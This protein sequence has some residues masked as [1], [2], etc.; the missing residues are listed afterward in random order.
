MRSPPL[1]SITTLS[2]ATQAQITPDNTLGNENSTVTPDA[3][4][5]GD[6]ADLIEGGA[7]REGNLF[8]SFLEFN[9]AE[10]QRVYFANPEGIKSILSRVTGG[11]LSNIF[12]VLGV[13]GAADLFLL[14]PN[15]I[16]FGENAT[17]DIAGSFYATTAAAIELGDEVFSAIEP[18]RS[19]L[20]TVSPSVLFENHLSEASG[21]IENQGQIFADENLTLAANQLDLQ[22]QIAAGRNLTLLATDEVQIRDTAAAPFIA[23]A[24]GDLLVQGNQQVD[25]V[26][27]SH[28]DSGLYSYG[29]MVLRSEERVGGDTHYLSGGSFRVEDLDG[30]IGTLH[31]PVDPIVRALGDVNIGIYQGSSLHILAGGSVSIGTA[32]IT[33]RE[34]ANLDGDFLQ[35]TIT[36]SNGTVI[37]IDGNAQPTLDVRAGVNADAIGTPPLELLTG[38]DPT[39]D[40]FSVDSVA[41][42]TPTS[43]DITIGDVAVQIDNGLVLLTNQYEAN[44]SLTGGNIVINGNGN[45]GNGINALNLSGQGGTVFIDGRNN[46]EVINSA[47]V[48]IALGEVGDIQLLAGETVR[49]D[50][51]D[52]SRITGAFAGVAPDGE[53]IGGEVLIQSANL[54]VLNGAQIN[55]GVIGRGAGGNVILDIADTARFVGF[56]PSDGSSSGAV[57]RIDSDGEGRGG[58]VVIRANT[59]EVLEGAQLSTSIFG[60]GEAGDVILEIANIA[61]FV[62][63]NPS[64]GSASG[65]FSQIDSDGEGRSGDVV[66]RANTLEVLEGAQLSAA[67]LGKGEAGNVILE[68]ADTA[69]F[70]GSDPINGI[71]SG[72]FSIIDSDGEG[73][74]GDIEIH[75]NT[76]EVLEGAQL[77]AGIL[78]EGEAG[79]VILEI[80]NTARFAGSN[81]S[82][83]SPSGVFNQIGRNGDGRGGDIEIHANTLEVLEG[84]QL[85]A[86]ILGEGEAGNVI[87]EIT[88]TARFA[89]S[90]PSDGSPSGVFNQIGRNGD[91]RGGDIEIHANTL[92]VLEGAQL[93]AGTF[94][95]GEAGNIILEIAETARFVGNNSS[96][97]SPSGVFN[98]IGRNGDGRGGDIEIHA[99]TLEVLE[100]AQLSA[101][102]FGAGEAG[103]VILEIADTARFV[104]SNPND[105]SPSGAFNQI[106]PDGA[107]RGG[108]V[109][110]HANT[111]EVLE[112]ATL[113][114][115]TFGRGEAGSVILE[116]ADTARFVGVDSIDGGSSGAFSSIEPD[117]D[118]RGGN[119]EIR[120]N[121]LE[122]LEGAQLGATT[123]G[124]GPAG[125]VIL[126]I[127]G[128]ARFVGFN[129]IINDISSGVLSAIGPDGEGAGGDI[130]IRAMNLEVLRGAQLIAVTLEQGNAGNIFLEIADTAR[131]V[132]SSPINGAP[133]GAFSGVESSGEGSGGDIE[134]RAA[135]LEILQAAAL[136]ADSL[137]NGDAGDIILLVS[138]QILV[139]DGTIGTNSESNSGGL[140]DIHAGSIILRND[141][142]IQTFIARGGGQ[143]GGIT[144]AADFVIALE[145]SDILAFSPDGRGGE[146]DLSQTTL[147]SQT[148][149]LAPD[150]LSREELLA[151]DG[152]DQVDVNATGGISSG[153]ISIN[154]ASF[155]ENSLNELSGDL[156]NTETLTAGSCIARTGGAE[157]SFVVTGGEGLPQQP[158]GSAISAYPTGAIQTMPETDANQTIQEPEGIFQLIDGRLVL[159]HKCD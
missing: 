106:G 150:N 149:N 84:A 145:D 144:I 98:Q 60:E 72:V 110:I 96:D 20:L 154:D 33:A 61:S 119:V 56:D 100:G 104:G 29:D 32:V 67:T 57:S 97:G 146:I 80:T 81:P 36:L 156:V 40:A 65:A 27:L 137:G 157:G 121:T 70:Q 118:G 54:E 131:F 34:G 152:N 75:A 64:D 6:L 43:A 5:R 39:I 136:F 117:G 105:G 18:E 23:F 78:G 19:R 73:R 9:V 49:F 107:G 71:S 28:P 130:K 59:L 153:Q 86:G 17:L 13:D 24:G 92:E 74:G 55:S 89:G 37:E 44:D 62:G 77:S 94:G 66:I 128:T 46:I 99:N 125:D 116:I 16:V 83:G 53:G 88:N 26:A 135:N 138:E 11:D 7:A 41:N 126:E 143:G 1:L 69:R 50:G 82:D 51:T 115:S 52:G 134:I 114:T 155:I 38:F 45:F 142:D 10:G 63:F 79:N 95:M 8:H 91:G 113:S 148:L 35:E 112:G 93:S 90:N 12:G 129:P 31:S 132:G 103:D 127:V 101:G 42:Q 159:S 140:V 124:E 21:D 85:S 76:L 109:E 123:F 139:D 58:D 122:V 158:G 111:L 3:I 30:N 147:F 14:N 48:T 87:L 120:A 15:G 151:L 47:I 68:I 141:G 108:N 102:T 2:T 133:S 4:V 22:G 25:I